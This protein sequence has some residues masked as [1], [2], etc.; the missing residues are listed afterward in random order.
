MKKIW[1]GKKKIYLLIV[2]AVIIGGAVYFG[3]KK[4]KVK[5]I[6]TSGYQYRD[7]GLFLA[8]SLNDLKNDVYF[9]SVKNTTRS[10]FTY[11]LK[12]GKY[13]Y[14]AGARNNY[15]NDYEK[16]VFLVKRFKK[17]TVNIQLK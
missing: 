4:G 16:G 15:E 11:T 13:Y 14:L 9:E 7:H 3:T 5:I 12:P 17:T 10:T 6:I 2:I 1:E 8:Y